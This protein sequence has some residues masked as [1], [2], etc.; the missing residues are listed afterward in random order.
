[1]RRWDLVRC[2]RDERRRCAERSGRQVC[3]LLRHAPQDAQKRRLS[4]PEQIDLGHPP[5]RNDGPRH[6]VPRR[7][8]ARH[9]GSARFPSVGCHTRHMSLGM[10][11]IMLWQPPLVFATSGGGTR[12]VTL[13]DVLLRSASFWVTRRY[14]A[15]HKEQTR[16]RAISEAAAAIRRKGPERVGVRDHGRGWPHPR[17]LLRAP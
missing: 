14:D 16:Q 11:N 12:W 9:A 7:P 8:S 2:A 6:A 5:S 17:W 15:S 3:P 4:I 10:S 1:M 13:L